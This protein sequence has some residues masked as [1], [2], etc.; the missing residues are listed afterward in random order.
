MSCALRSNKFLE[1]LTFTWMTLVTMILKKIDYLKRLVFIITFLA[2]LVYRAIPKTLCSSLMILL[3]SVVLAFHDQLYYAKN[4]LSW[5]EKDQPRSPL[6]LPHLCFAQPNTGT[7]SMYSQIASTRPL[8]TSYISMPHWKQELKSTVQTC[9]GLKKL[10]NNV[11]TP[12]AWK[13]PTCSRT[14]SPPLV[15]SREKREI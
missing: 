7:T 10:S 6:I 1:I 5:T 12:S 15:Y 3:F 13:K 11:R 4:W 9:R 2:P 14:P 8:L